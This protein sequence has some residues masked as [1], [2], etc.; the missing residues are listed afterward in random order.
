MQ[1]QPSADKLER[2]SADPPAISYCLSNVSQ[3]TRRRLKCSGRVVIEDVCLQRCGHC[4]GGPF[5]LVGERLVSGAS[6]EE[7]LQ[8]IDESPEVWR[9]P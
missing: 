2:S 1:N 5:L 8:S 4:F 9:H 7:M 6:H 3:E